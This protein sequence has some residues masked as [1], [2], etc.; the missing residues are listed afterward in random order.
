MWND[1]SNFSVLVTGAT[2]GIGLATA[3][4]FGRLGANVTITHKW[5]SVSDEELYEVFEAAG[6]TKPLIFCAD[7][8]ESADTE[9]LLTAIKSQFGSLDVFV[10]NVSFAA[11]PKGLDDYTLRGLRTSVDY[12]VWPLIEHVRQSQKVFGAYPR[13]IVGMS[14]FGSVSMHSNYDFAGPTKAMLE[15]FCRYLAHRLRHEDVRVNAVR[16]RYVPTDSLK[17]TAGEGFVDFVN[18]LDPS[19]FIEPMEVGDAIVALCSGAMDAMTGQVLTVDNGTS[20]RDNL[21]G[22]YERSKTTSK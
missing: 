15:T 18:K 1:F 6:A 14:S 10:S 12:S 9:E 17:S 20:F 7:A 13:Y 21:M 4:A 11:V 19:L 8:R 3:I 2:K 16:T 5:G 22:A